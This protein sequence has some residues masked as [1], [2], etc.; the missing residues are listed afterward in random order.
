MEETTENMAG[1]GFSK[2]LVDSNFRDVFRLVYH[3][4][5]VKAALNNTSAAQSIFTI[6]KWLDDK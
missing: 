1:I 3:L 5:W 2:L 6:S 4:L